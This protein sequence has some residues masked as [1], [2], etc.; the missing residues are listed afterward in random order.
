MKMKGDLFRDQNGNST[1]FTIA[2]T[3]ACIFILLALFE[4]CYIYIVREKTKTVSESIAL[5]VSQELLFLNREGIR[6]IAEEIAKE[7]GC[8]LTGLDA[9]YDEVIVSVEKDINIAVL[10]RIGPGR[11]KTVCSSSSVKIIYPWDRE[12]GM[13]RYYEF[14]YKPY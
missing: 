3:I 9:G 10:G 8:R 12:L 1:I 4:L 5:A 7:S 11:L 14:G 2:L 6:G 13:C